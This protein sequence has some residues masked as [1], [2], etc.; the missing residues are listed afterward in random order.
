M[1]DEGAIR[2]PADDRERDGVDGKLDLLG[3]RAP[4]ERGNEFGNIDDVTFDTDTGTLE[5]SRRRRTQD[6]LHR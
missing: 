1:V 6:A 5:E 4:S 3:K 2:P